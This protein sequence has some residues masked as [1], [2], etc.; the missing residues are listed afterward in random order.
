MCAVAFH[1][2]FSVV[3]TA[4]ED[5]TMRVYDYETGEYER[6]LKGHTNSVQDLA[7]GAQGAL[8]GSGRHSSRNTFSNQPHPT[9]ASC[10]ADLSIKIWNCE[11]FECAKTLRGFLGTHIFASN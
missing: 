3:V 4:S 10:S 7:F 6:S 11:Q 8:L 9:A 2:V 5:G 1:P